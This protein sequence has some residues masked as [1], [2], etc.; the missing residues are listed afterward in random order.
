MEIINTKEIKKFVK[1][2]LCIMLVIMV[3]PIILYRN[4]FSSDFSSDSQDWGDF[5]GYI[6]GVMGTVFSFMAVIF[7]L[8]SIYITLKIATRIYEEEEKLHRENDEREIKKFE[9]EIELIYCQNKPLPYIFEDYSKKEISIYIENHGVGSLKIN[10]W[11]VIYENSEFDHFET[12]VDKLTA[13]VD[14]NIEWDDSKIHMLA[15]GKNKNLFNV[16]YNGDKNE[17]D[18]EYIDYYNDYIKLFKKVEISFDCEDIFGNKFNFRH[19][20][21]V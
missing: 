2:T 5:G 13:D 11:K 18:K 6:G 3:V 12:L 14:A 17:P 1:I 15:S 9:R 8:L 20:L 7:S 16:K 10:S 19:K 21:E 4:K